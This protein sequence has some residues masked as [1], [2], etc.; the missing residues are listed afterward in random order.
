MKSL[1][2]IQSKFI[3]PFSNRILLLSVRKIRIGVDIKILITR[4]RFAVAY[5]ANIF[6]EISIKDGYVTLNLDNREIK[7]EN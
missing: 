1:L 5:L 7:R 3:D 2:G 6:K 4:A